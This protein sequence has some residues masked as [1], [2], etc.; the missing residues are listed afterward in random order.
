MAEGGVELG[1]EGTGAGAGGDD[2]FGFELAV[3]FGDG[4]G[5]DDELGGEA[6]DGG[7]FL[8]FGEV[9]EGD[10]AF[11]VVDDLLIDRAGG[12]L[13]EIKLHCS[14]ENYLYYMY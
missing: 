6:T 5:I 9:A 7:E 2:A 13:I 14:S 3:R 8:A 10:F 1:D 12:R 11:Y 4:V